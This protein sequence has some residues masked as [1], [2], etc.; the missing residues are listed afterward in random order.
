MATTE[1]VEKNS[2]HADEGSSD[3]L[4]HQ[5]QN[6]NQNQ[7][8]DRQSTESR[9]KMKRSVSVYTNI[10]SAPSVKLRLFSPPC[11]RQK[12]GSDQILPHVNWGDL[13]FD[14]FYVAAFYNLGNILVGDPSWFGI[15]YFLGCYFP[16]LGLWTQKCYYDSQFTYGDDI[17]HK[18]F[19]I[20]VLVVLATNVSSI[21]PVPRMSNPNKYVDMFCFSLSLTGSTLLDCARY[22]ECYW[23]G[24][25]QRKN[26]AHVATVALQ[27][28]ILP[29]V[30]YVASTIVAG[31]AFF[32][33]S[34][35]G[36]YRRELTGDSDS[37]G[38]A[39]DCDNNNQNHIPIILLLVG[40]FFAQFGLIVR[41]GCFYPKHGN[42]KKLTIPMNI[43]FFIHRN[44]ELTMLV[45]GESVLSLLI[46]DGETG[47]YHRTFY[48]GIVTVVLLQMLHFQ[49]Q[50]HDADAHAMRRHKN[51]GLLFGRVFPM[52]AAALITVGA[53]YK[54][55][56]Y[57]SSSDSKKRRL[58]SEFS[59]T[60]YRWLAGGSGGDSGCGPSGEEME[61]MVAHLFSWAMA[62]VFVCLD[63]MTLAHVGL[64]EV[65]RC[66][67]DG[68]AKYNIKGIFLVVLPRGL[69]TI[70]IATLSLW[71]K[72]PSTLAG[73]GL[74]AVVCQL[75]TRFMG[76]VWFSDHDSRNHGHA[77]GHTH[78]GGIDD[79]DKECISEDEDDIAESEAI[80]EA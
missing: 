56:M 62:I 66:K 19:E 23:F 46:V 37:D 6:Q 73:L 70:F 22:L 80:A 29:L 24:R 79:E 4:P 1:S 61:Q 49:S 3:V 45:L 77:D 14:L 31:M 25:G 76:N 16:V 71:Q 59:G 28:Q 7:N 64:K 54:L 72:D 27:Y 13:F 60:G 47:N 15:L 36:D 2:D 18:V 26:I 50:P 48:F 75:A 33:N 40:Y 42:H 41:V 39:T 51:S 57:S 43:D 67:L 35:D 74:A 58:I 38:A 10:S 8:Q 68:V 21:A 11:Q 78:H 63:V 34:Y 9:S 20:V 32:G 69:V 17:L 5:N 30:C 44:G 65:N 53:S 12:W 55:F 52:Y